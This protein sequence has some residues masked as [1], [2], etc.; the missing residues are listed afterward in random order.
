MIKKFFVAF[1][2]A[3]TC[4]AAFG[5]NKIIDG[6][7]QQLSVTKDDTSRALIFADLSFAIAFQSSDSALLYANKAIELAKQIHFPRGE[8]RGMFCKASVLETNGDMPE[9]LELGFS[10]LEM[11][12]K[13]NLLLEK[14]MCLTLIGNVFYDLND[15]T[16]AISFYQQATPINEM[17]KNQPGTEFWKWQTEVNLG[18]AFMLN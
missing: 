13:E 2:S 15:Y 3:I 8:I 9:A 6:I 7:R 12:E 5:Q 18:T 14:S 17:I 11:A 10:A 4:M 16:K 1:F